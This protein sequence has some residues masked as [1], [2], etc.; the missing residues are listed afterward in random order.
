[1]GGAPSTS[2]FRTFSGSVPFGRWISAAGFIGADQYADFVVSG[3]ALRSSCNNTINII[4]GNATGTYPATGTA[5]NAIVAPAG[6]LGFGRSIAS[7]YPWLFA[8]AVAR[9]SGNS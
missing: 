6:A 9:R 1:M 2:I 7:R 3:C 5:P 8:P 4:H